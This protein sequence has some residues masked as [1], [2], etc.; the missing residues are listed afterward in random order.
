MRTSF[1]FYLTPKTTPHIPFILFIVF[2]TLNSV[3]MRILKTIYDSGMSFVRVYPKIQGFSFHSFLTV[4][5]DRPGGC[6]GDR[7][8]PWMRPCPT[9]MSV[10]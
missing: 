9:T 3:I 7:L 8:L 6:P 10:A 5:D 2:I 4:A 1:A